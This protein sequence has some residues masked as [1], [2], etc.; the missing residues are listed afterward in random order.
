MADSAST[1]EHAN[2]LP[3]T[4][5]I[6]AIFR[7]YGERYIAQYRPCMEEIQLIR[8]I[9]KC[10]TPYLGGVVLQC[11]D[12]DVRRI[13][14]KSCGASRCPICQSCKRLQLQEKLRNRL[15]K[16]PY[17]HMI[18]TVPH[19]LNGLFRLNQKELYSLLYRVSWKALKQCASKEKHLGALPGMIS[20]MHS[21]G[22]DMKYHV[23]L[24]ALVTFGGI[25]EAGN[26]RYPK[27]KDKLIAYRE[28]NATYKSCF[29]Q[30]LDKLI[31]KRALRHNAALLSCLEN[32]RQKNWVVHSTKPQLDTKVLEEYLSRYVCKIAVSNSRLSYDQIK[33]QVY[34]I[35][36]DYRNQLEGEA[37][38]KKHRVFDPLCF[39]HQFLQHLP[40]K[41]F[42]RTRYYGIHASSKYKRIRNKLPKKLLRIGKTI[43]TL[44][45]IVRALIG[46]EGLTCDGCG[47]YDLVRLHE[48]ADQEWLS[49]HVP[50]FQLRAPPSS[51]HRGLKGARVVHS[52]NGRAMSTGVNPAVFSGSTS[53]KSPTK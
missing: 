18:F 12:C 33:H 47:G 53:T 24:H 42:Q 16:V 23:H 15:L 51:A 40:P 5:T 1:C 31:A 7:E 21:W 36:N 17:V 43:R 26:W 35:Y 6:G 45:Q 9:R 19:E 13:I 25:E 10:R 14:Y 4:N 44:F 37:A 41:S 32:A 39:I 29:L 52:G 48:P 11:S 8:N 2:R 28:L 27:R 34:L 38:P 22:S 46:E 30:A 3:Y 49:R 20:V 50:G